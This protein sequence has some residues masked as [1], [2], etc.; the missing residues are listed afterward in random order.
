MSRIEAEAKPILSPLI[1]ARGRRVHRREQRTLA[2][3]GL[4]KACGFDELHPRERVV[5]SEHRRHLYES[6]E[7]PAEGL[8]VSLAT[9]EA[10]DVGHYAYQ[11]LRLGKT[12]DPAPSEAT[13]YFVTI[14]IGALVVQIVGSAL[15]DWTFAAVPYPA[16]LDVAEI[17]PAS[18]RVEFSQRNVMVHDTLI[19]YTKVLYNVVGKLVGGAP[20]AR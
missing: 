2:T 15:P 10:R 7:P 14:T 16:E 13:V 3:W 1:H 18:A 20:P 4:L 17:W 11:G 19:G 9:Y 5:L 6:H 8:W 12:S